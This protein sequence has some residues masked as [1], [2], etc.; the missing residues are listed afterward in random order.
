MLRIES[1]LNERRRSMQEHAVPQPR[2]VGHHLA[3]KTLIVLVILL[4]A[5]F[6]APLAGEMHIGAHGGLT[7]PSLTGGTNPI[8]Q[9]YTSRLGPNFGIFADYAI[10]GHFSVRAEIDYSS[11]GG[12]R[13][14]M[15][16][17]YP[18]EGTPLPPDTPLPLYAVFDN[19]TI[20][21]Y[22][23]IP[24]MAELSWG[25]APRLFAAAGPY[26]GFLVRAKTV[27]KGS[28]LLY[29]DDSGTALPFPEQDFAAETDS[30]GDINSTNAG[31]AGGV[32]FELPYGPG[33]VVLEA[34]F[35]YGLTN[36]QKDTVLNGK[37]NTGMLAFTL[38]YSYPVRA[39]R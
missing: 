2:P 26:V 15:Q 39:K 17:Y 7:V 22:I 20:L 12:K 35:T 32:G 10:R 13:N 5:A 30:R 4:C 25:N 29:A 9:G 24:V 33:D 8:S 31:I 37:N 38:G 19:E 6:G 3:T 27:T 28:S 14:G 18:P 1:I 11:E 23:E 21:D 34:G 16:P 36:I